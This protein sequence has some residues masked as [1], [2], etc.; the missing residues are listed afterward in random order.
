MTKVNLTSKQRQSKITGGERHVS[1]LREGIA[2]QVASRGLFIFPLSSRLS[3]IVGLLLF[4]VSVFSAQAANIYVAQ[5]S[6]GLDTGADA[7]N[8]HSAAWFNTS[9]NWGTGAGKL[10]PGDTVHLTG[11]IS[12][13]LSVQAG[14]LSGHVTTILFEPGAKMSVPAWATAALTVGKDYITVDGGATGPIGG[15]NGN[16]ALANGIIEDTDNGAGLENQVG[17]ASGV[18]VNTANHVTVR[19]LVIRNLFVRA[20]GTDETS[21]G[22]QGVKADGCSS[23]LV[24]NCIFH[25]NEKGVLFVF[26]TGNSN[27]EY[28][29]T[30]AY[31][32]NWGGGAGPGSDGSTLTSLLVHDNY[33]YAWS[34]WDDTSTGNYYHHNGF[35]C[36]AT[37]SQPNSTATG[38]RY[39]NNQVGSGTSGEWGT[40][41][42]SGLWVQD[43][44][45]DVQTYN[46][47][48]IVDA[49]TYPSNG[50]IGFDPNGSITSTYRAYNN[51]LI[52]HSNTI[53]TAIYVDAW[54]VTGGSLSLSIRNNVIVGMRFAIVIFDNSPFS[55]TSDHNLVFGN[56]ASTPYS[57]STNS[58]GVFKSI[59]E[60]KGLGFDADLLVSDPLLDAKYLP[61]GA[62]AA[63][64]GGANLTTYFTTDKAGD[65]RASDGGWI[66]GAYSPPKPPTN[67]RIGPPE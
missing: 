10:N 18:F 60:W 23:L 29:F 36:F 38:I 31:N 2:R 39:Y 7:A 50:L 16:P 63:V 25:D 3:A 58:S 37:L 34:N 6:Q 43:K 8:A 33:F 65:S 42:S 59:A 53:G 51:T 15:P 56:D 54:Q 62:S 22:N 28:S 19:G 49:T 67:A 48:C 12:T 27:I 61:R 30:T 40:R 13:A 55:I 47:L 1:S 57:Y 5:T 4:L 26:R 9:G 35:F 44:I 52:G 64:G 21:N 66:I 20:S 46:N 45:Y 41:A 14:G 24:T 11:N 17:N 32:C